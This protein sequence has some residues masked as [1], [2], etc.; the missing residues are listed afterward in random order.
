MMDAYVERNLWRATPAE[1]FA[2][3]PL[4]SDATAD[5]AIVGGGFTGCS[6]A[7]RAAELGADVRLVEAERIGHGGS[8]RNVGLVNSGLWMPPDDINGLLGPEAGERLNEALAAAPDLVFSLIERYRIGCHAVRNG[9]LH[10]AHSPKGLDEL[11]SRL[12]QLQAR[13]APVELLDAERTRKRTGTAAFHGALYDE[14]AGT[15]EPFAFCQGLARAA[16]EQGAR[17]HEG[18][19]VARIRHD[20]QAW[21]VETA[22]A[23]LTARK[24]LLATNAYH[25]LEGAADVDQPDFTPV[26]FFLFATRPLD[27]G[28]LASILPGREGCWD[29]GT[30]MSAFRR[31]HDGRLLVG[32]LGALDHPGSAVHRGWARKKLAALFPA[33]RD[34][35]FDYAW[36]GRIAM[37]GDHLPKIVRLPGDGLTIFGYSGRGIAPGTL[38]GRSAGQALVT[39][40]TDALPLPSR[41]GYGERRTAL[42]RRFFEAGAVA[43]HLAWMGRHPLA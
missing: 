8:G 7:L 18:S 33:L 31:D 27:D 32:S 28:R 10:V 14:R 2:G 20:G 24:L 11:R 39:G 40:D 9:T 29:T 38:F 43:D 23:T 34:E 41:E 21:R 36:H 15:I 5:L 16:S 42:R 4:E 30:V 35:P 37:T 1:S 12:A 26:H 19:P 25:R 6:A 22:D 3:G 13:A 17:I